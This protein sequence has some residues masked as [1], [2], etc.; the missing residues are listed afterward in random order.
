ME[1]EEAPPPSPESAGGPSRVRPA[2]RGDGPA[3]ARLFAEVPMAG[4]L[5]LSTRRDPDFF[6]L[7]DIQRGAAECQVFEHEGRVVGL[8]TALV[9]SGW[10]DGQVRTVGY[11]GDLRVGPAGRRRRALMQNFGGELRAIALR[12]QCH[13]FLTGILASNAAAINALVRRRVA[14][15]GK[16]RYWPFR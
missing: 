14:R 2:V 16:P 7:Y 9:R 1:D 12:H 8:G 10:I 4:S 6:A 3:L 15:Q 13:L 5:V 11:L